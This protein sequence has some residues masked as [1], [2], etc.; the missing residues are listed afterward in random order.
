MEEWCVSGVESER[1]MT[2]DEVKLIC[3]GA[4]PRASSWC[5]VYFLLVFMIH[6]ATRYA[7]YQL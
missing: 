6:E 2:Q 1:E 5:E 3:Q 7:H 4:T